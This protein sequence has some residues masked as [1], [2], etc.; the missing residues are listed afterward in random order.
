MTTGV[1][2]KETCVKVTE[3]VSPQ[4]WLIRRVVLKLRKAYNQISG[5]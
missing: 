2:H 3:W 4:E 5:S 1:D